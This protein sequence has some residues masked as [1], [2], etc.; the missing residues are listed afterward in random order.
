MKKSFFLPLI[1]AILVMTGCSK[2]QDFVYLADMTENVG[3]PMMLKHEARIQR[4]D[5]LKIIV[6]SKNPAL[7]APF[8]VAGGNVQVDADGNVTSSSTAPNQGYR[9]DSRGYIDFPVLGK[10]KVEGMTLTEAAE[11]IRKKIIAS[12]YIKDP[13]VNVDFTNFRYTV[14]GA[15][16]SNGTFNAEGD[17]VTLLEAIARAGDLGP[18]ADMGKIAVIREEG[19]ERKIYMHDIR[20]TDLFNSPCFYLQQN[21]I[22]YAVPMEPKKK[23]DSKQNV[24]PWLSILLSAVTA[25]TSIIWATR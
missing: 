14:M 18:T 6:S 4:D 15:V 24:L 20:S 8:N 21:D 22:V 13:M 3:Y 11:T 23:T 17:R 12:G 5:R 19:N 1:A 2:Q 7:A 16:G 9:V 10:I 25:A